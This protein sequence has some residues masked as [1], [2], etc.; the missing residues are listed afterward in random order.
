MRGG[1][2]QHTNAMRRFSLWP[3]L[4]LFI[5]FCL[6]CSVE[7]SIRTTRSM[8]HGHLYTLWHYPCPN[9]AATHAQSFAVLGLRVRRLIMLPL[10]GGGPWSRITWQKKERPLKVAISVS[11]DSYHKP[12][13]T[14]VWKCTPHRTG[15]RVTCFCLVAFFFKKSCSASALLLLLLSFFLLNFRK[16]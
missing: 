14:S 8:S 10:V 9:V 7:L 5:Y 11:L 16:L 4:Y 12:P 3:W 6:A 15:S 2:K 1:K 13:P